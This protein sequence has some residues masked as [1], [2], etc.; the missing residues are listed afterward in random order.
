MSDVSLPDLTWHPTQAYSSRWGLKPRF[1]VNHTWGVSSWRT[2]R[3]SGV[4]NYFEAVSNQVSA[5]FVYAGRK[6]P[7]DEGA[8]VQMVDLAHKSWTEAG[9]NAIGV[10]IESSDYIWRG[11]DPE[12]LLQLARIN[13]WLLH[14]L[15]LP[16][17]YIGG[18]VWQKG[19]TRHGDLGLKGGGHFAC[20]TTDMALWSDFCGLVRDEY[21]R[22]GYRPIWAR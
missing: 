9:Y 8:C 6:E 19:F 20:P 22:G 7:G 15:G 3:I 4:V 14:H 11:E 21:R 18:K 5:H 16:A 13:G 12:G 1:V 17:Q 10:S 2:E